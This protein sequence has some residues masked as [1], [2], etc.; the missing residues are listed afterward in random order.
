MIK[1]AAEDLVLDLYVE[2]APSGAAM[3]H[4]PALPGLNFRAASAEEIIP[5]GLEAVNA[6]VEW[7]ATRRLTA[8]TPEAQAVFEAISSE[9]LRRVGLRERER[10]AGAPVWESGNAAA[11]FHIDR[12]VLSNELVDAHLR[13]VRDLL[14]WI[15]SVVTSLSS[16]QRARTPSPDRRSIDKTLEHIGNC[17]WWYLS[18]MDDTLPEPADVEG[19]DQVDR[20]ERLVELASDTLL[21]TPLARRK[22]VYTPTRYP[23]ADREESWTHAK[24]CRREAEHVWAH[25]LGIFPAIR[26][27]LAGR[28]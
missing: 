2:V 17:I 16:E 13:L 1:S 10:V 8:L 26:A 6:Y 3:G 19:E 22:T 11:L 24:V 20:M 7:I 5:Q 4:I 25:R 28:A 18:R 12:R 14:A 15:R 27:L 9:S 23:T 21:G